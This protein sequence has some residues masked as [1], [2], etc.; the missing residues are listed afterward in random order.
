M[1][2]EFVKSASQRPV[3][4][5]KAGIQPAVT[6]TTNLDPGFRRDDNLLPF[7]CTPT[8]LDPGFRRDDDLPVSS[9]RNHRPLSSGLTQPRTRSAKTPMTTLSAT[10]TDRGIEWAPVLFGLAAMYVPTFVD[11]FMGLWRSDEQMHGPIILAVSLY[12]FWSLRHAIQDAPVAPRRAVAWPLL[13]FG[14]L[15]YILGRSQGIILF[16]LGSLIWILPALLL[17]QRGTQALKACWFPIFFLFFMIPLPGPIVDMLT[18]PMK[19]FVS[20]ATEHVLYAAGYPISRNGVILYLG[21]YQL[22]VADVC[23]G[24]HTLFSLEAM[25]LF[26]LHITRHGS[27][28]RNTLLAILIIPISLAANTIRVMSLSLITYYLGDEAGQGFLHG[29]AGMVLFVSA[30][31]LIMAIDGL[32]QFFLNRGKARAGKSQSPRY[33]GSFHPLS[34]HAEYPSHPPLP[35]SGERAMVRGGGPNP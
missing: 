34:P 19:T 23:A 14:L 13:I 9:F 4:P 11:L 6:P 16:E 7:P 27:W 29:F 30:L 28:W 20:W 21:Q 5:A 10:R 26:Y 8:N 2:Q 17:M 15:L 24:L 31:I 3:I 25:G 12:L 18:L 1:L 22:L 32:I 33:G 35:A